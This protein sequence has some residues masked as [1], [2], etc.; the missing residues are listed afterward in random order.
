MIRSSG[1]TTGLDEVVPMALR[2]AA[3]HLTFGSD[4]FC[5]SRKIPL[6]A[7]RGPVLPFNEFDEV[8]LSKLPVD[9][10]VRHVSG[11]TD[12]TE[13]YSIRMAS[14]NRLGNLMNI[15]F[16]AFLQ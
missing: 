10:H 2:L 3:V 7:T 15:S 6:V 13:V 11:S 1:L 8:D 5:R 9:S 12:F 16:I 4:Q 14:M